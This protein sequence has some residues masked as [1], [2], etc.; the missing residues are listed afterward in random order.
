M[1]RVLHCDDD[2]DVGDVTTRILERADGRLR[3]TSVE[4]PADA[5]AGLAD[6]DCLVTDS[7]ALPDGEPLAVA[8]RERRPDLPVVFY[9]GREWRTVAPM[10]ES[11][12]AAGY[13]R[14]S[15]T[16]AYETLARRLTRLADGDASDL[17]GAGDPEAALTAVRAGT[18]VST[19]P[20]D[21]GWRVVDRHDWDA[22]E[23]VVAVADAVADAE[24]VPVHGVAPLYDVI[25]GEALEDLL[26][27]SAPGTRVTFA[28]GAVELGVDA[29]GL[30]AVRDATAVAGR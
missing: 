6:V 15:G 2:A 18:A 23:L 21:E 5:L 25:D 24:G 30:V 17:S 26:S 11:I 22:E 4:D 28:H 7:V 16:T 20:M 29:D 12:G 27:R 3:V 10:A 13:V 19:F 14:K 8:A 9:T 1:Y